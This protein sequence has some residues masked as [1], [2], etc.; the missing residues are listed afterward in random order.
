M[1]LNYKEIS[2]MVLIVII[3]PIIISI[4]FKHLRSSQK[5]NEIPK[6][7]Y[8]Q[9]T[10]NL[11][12]LFQTA[13]NY[14]VINI[15]PR[16]NP[17]VYTQGLYYNNFSI[18]ESGGLYQKSTLTQMEWPSQK[19][20]KQIQLDNKYF[21]EG[22]A[23]DNDYLYQLT[24]REKEI[25]VYSMKNMELIKK[26]KM[27][28]ELSEGWG[29][30][31]GIKKN[32]FLATDGSDKIFTLKLNE[33]D[34]LFV[35]SFINV[36][37]NFKRIYR[38]NELI[39][40]GTYIYCN[41]YLTK[42]ILKINPYNGNVL[43]VYDMQPLVDYELKNGKLT[44]LNLQRGDVLNGIVYIPDRKSFILTGKMWNFYY[45]VQFQN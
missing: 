28:N 13:K 10:S 27:P 19:I 2:L 9:K 31:L 20:I 12:N 40:D 29:M 25:L 43:N 45:E 41:V 34:E 3:F 1:L 24:Y 32:E 23:A 36:S 39:F 17:T 21:A 22:I 6:D 42:E 30:S 38:L 35:S 33:N 5:T 16:K 18:Y 4:S 14:K 37:Y 44:N 15:F 8:T 26:I 7:Y 11:E